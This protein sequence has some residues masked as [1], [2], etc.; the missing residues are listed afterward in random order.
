MMTREKGILKKVKVHEAVG[1]LQVFYANIDVPALYSMESAD[2]SFGI[3]WMA[4]NQFKFEDL[5]Q[6][7]RVGD[8]L[9]CR[10][11]HHPERKPFYTRG[12]FW[13]HCITTRVPSFRTY[14]PPAIFKSVNGRTYATMGSPGFEIDENITQKELQERWISLAPQ[15]EARIFRKKSSRSNA[16]YTIRLYPDGRMNCNCPGFAFHK[17]DCWHITEVREELKH[18][19]D[20]I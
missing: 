12:D 15:T 9:E 14:Y 2:S 20:A 4:G 16:R 18:E 10:F 19:K 11:V 3:T 6:L 13:L 7:R 17:K 5:I 8:V 1:D